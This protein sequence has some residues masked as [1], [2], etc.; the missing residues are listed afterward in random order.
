MKGNERQS[1]KNK[2]SKAILTRSIVLSVIFLIVTYWLITMAISTYRVER[3]YL[4]KK[5]ESK[6]LD[7]QVQM[8][9][10]SNT[11]PEDIKKERTVRENL[12]KVK[13]GEDLIVIIPKE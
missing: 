9:Q 8:I 3:A 12:Q 5:R 13:P 1:Q 4:I 10:N 7:N 11:E 2:I 6:M